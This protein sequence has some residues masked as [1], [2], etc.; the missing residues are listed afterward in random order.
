MEQAKQANER[1]YQE[2]LGL[3]NQVADIYKPGGTFGRQ[4]MKELT[5]AGTQR[6]VGAGLYG[7]TVKPVSATQQRELADIRSGRYATALAGKAGAIE[8]R[9]DIGPDLGM[10][11][12]LLMQSW[13]APGGMPAG[14]GY[15]RRW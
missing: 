10:F 13:S 4:T 8:R 6:L 15:G 1:R 9:E 2:T 7:T 3:W 5:A 11:A 12:N 14:Y